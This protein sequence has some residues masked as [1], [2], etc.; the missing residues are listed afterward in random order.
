MG[1]SDTVLWWSLLLVVFAAAFTYRDQILDVFWH[2]PANADDHLF[3]TN[4]A[5]WGAHIIA[6]G[7]GGIL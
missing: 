6:S 3:A 2:R 5:K 4:P 7:V 1:D